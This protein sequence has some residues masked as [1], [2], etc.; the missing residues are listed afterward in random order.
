MET[1]VH[2]IFDNNIR[3]PQYNIYYNAQLPYT[4]MHT[5]FNPLSSRSIKIKKNSILKKVKPPGRERPQSVEY[6]YSIKQAKL[7]R[8]NA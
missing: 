3:T 2:Y 6:K 7:T 1:A 8:F 5:I 4:P